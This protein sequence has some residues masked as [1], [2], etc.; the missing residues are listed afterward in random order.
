MFW[1]PFGHARLA[2]SV[3]RWTLNPTVVGSSPTLGAYFFVC[4]L[5][6]YFP[7]RN[8]EESKDLTEVQTALAAHDVEKGEIEGRRPK[9]VMLTERAL[10]TN[11]STTIDQNWTVL[12]DRMIDRGNR[13]DR[14]K[15]QLQYHHEQQE[16]KEQLDDISSR[17]NHTTKPTDD[18]EVFRQIKTTENIKGKVY[19]FYFPLL[20]ASS[21]W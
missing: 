4:K 14:E 7:S 5:Y 13:L 16:L 10:E 1:S 8:T 3:E 6:F 11:Q 18:A 19:I 2:Q 9:L 21:Y 17:I 20:V 15:E 12:N